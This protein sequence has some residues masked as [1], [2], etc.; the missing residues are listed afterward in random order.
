M[1]ATTNAPSLAEHLRSA[2]FELILSSGFFGFYAHAGVIAALQEEGL[3]P[4]LFGGSSAGALVAS[5]CAAGMPADELRERLFALRRQEFWD[6]DPRLG[7]GPHSHG[8][9]LLRGGAF[10]EILLR[11]FSQLGVRTFADCRIPLRVVVYG[12]QER[13]TVVLD[14]GELA[15]AVRASCTL[16]VLFQPVSIDGKR[17]LDGGISDRAGIRAATP[18]ARVLYHHLAPKSPWR[19]LWSAQNAP[20][21]WPDLHLLY[22]PNTPRLGPFS[23]ER[24]PKAYEAARAEARRVLRS[25]AHL[26][27]HPS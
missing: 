11:S 13:A 8:P 4:A 23:L 9:G 27:R 1:H 17:Y 18:G 24:G 26:S 21:R 5:L 22:A 6:F 2:P 25:P 16:P 19:F 15:A 12:I 10:A 14:R 7:T 20:P 3:V